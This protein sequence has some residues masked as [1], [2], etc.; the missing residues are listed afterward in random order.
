MGVR[1]ILAFDGESIEIMEWELKRRE[2]GFGPGAILFVSPKHNYRGYP[3]GM[4]GRIT[5]TRTE[6]KSE[7]EGL[8]QLGT[9]WFDQEDGLQ[10][11]HSRVIKFMEVTIIPPVRVT[12][13]SDWARWNGGR[14]TH[15]YTDGS[16]A[17]DNTLGQFLLGKGNT[18][19]GGAI[20]LSDGESWVYRI[21]VR[22]DVKV[23]KAF[24]VELICIL[25]ANE[26]LPRVAESR[27]TRTAKPPLMWLMAPGQW[28]SETL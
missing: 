21:L 25:I 8:V 27:F 18:K 6:F 13:S 1:E 7:A 3:T 12:Y 4:G 2:D 14:I 19:V 26:R 15:I 23:T 10:A 16:H 20:I 24:D 5:I 22:I 9:D 11:I 28:T 17:R